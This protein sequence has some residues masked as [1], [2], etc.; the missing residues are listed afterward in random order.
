MHGATTL[1]SRVGSFGSSDSAD[2]QTGMNGPPDPTLEALWK[3]VVDHWDDDK[4]HSSFLEYCTSS[5]RLVEAAVRYRGM[6]GDHA[7]SEVAKKRLESVTVLAM[8]RLDA[9]RRTERPTAGRA[10]SYALIAFFVFATIGL[11]AYLGTTR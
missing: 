11:L 3:R 9:A 8:A 4:A 10:G 6:V 1:P 5:D 2:T 7:R